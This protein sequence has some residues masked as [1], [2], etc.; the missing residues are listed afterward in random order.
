[1]ATLNNARI[2]VLDSGKY[3]LQFEDESG[4]TILT[5]PFES[6]DKAAEEADRLRLVDP[7]Q[8]P[9]T[10]AEPEPTENPG[11]VEPVN[12]APVAEPL[13]EAT[14]ATA[15][16]AEPALPAEAPAEPPHAGEPGAPP[17]PDAD[18]A[19]DG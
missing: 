1:M 11:L 15:P 18:P 16:G 5:G 6:P 8:P 9:T 3:E 4:T 7:A 14:P 12:P 2:I 10:A 13:P 17:M 19:A